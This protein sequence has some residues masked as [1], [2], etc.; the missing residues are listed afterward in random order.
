MKL[1]LKDETIKLDGL[2]Y[3]M[4][5]AILC[6]MTIWKKHGME[7]VTVTSANDGDHIDGSLHY[8]GNAV[9]LRSRTLP[10]AIGMCDELRTKLP[11]SY[12]VLIYP[13][14]I[15]IEYDPK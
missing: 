3:E 11:L 8:S 12:D 14:H 15:H 6:C 7:S 4:L 10:D 13:T 2:S 5:A 1:K 9:D